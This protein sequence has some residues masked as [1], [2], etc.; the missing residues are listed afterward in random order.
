MKPSNDR[1]DQLGGRAMAKHA[2]DL[3]IV[4]AI[5]GAHGVQ[6]DV[7][8]RSFTGEPEALFD[9]APLL[10][11]SGEVLLDPVSVRVSKQQFIVKPRSKRS[12]ED[13]DALKG[14]NLFALRAK[15]PAPDEEEYYI[16]DLVG[17]DVFAGGEAVIGRVKAVL[18]HG[19]SD[20]LEIAPKAGGKPVLVPFT[21]A[22]VPTVDLALRRIIVATYEMWA[23]Q[24]R[25]EDAD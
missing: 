6:G 12:K 19:A 15:L 5:A 17:L 7:R 2:D 1:H 20:L 10:S 23:D 4:G 14:E 25:P 18:N 3:I 11:G 9:Y 13:W 21:E 16:S 22:D 8:V 24:S